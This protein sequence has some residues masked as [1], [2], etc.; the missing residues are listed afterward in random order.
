MTQALIHCLFFV[1]TLLA[2]SG[3]SPIRPAPVDSLPADP[4]AAEP[5]QETL[6][7]GHPLPEDLFPPGPPGQDPEM[8]ARYHYLTFLMLHRQNQ[9]DAAVTALEKAIEIDPDDSFLKRDLIRM[10][11]SMGQD[12]TA[13]SLLDSLV[14]QHPDN[15]EN[16]L[17]MARLKKDDM[18]DE[19]MHPLLE[20]ILELDPENRE[21]YLRLG[22]IYM[23]N[24]QIPEALELFSRM[25]KRLPD[26]YVAHF[27][28]GEAHFLS[29]NYEAAEQAFLRTIDLEPD[30]IEPRFRLVDILQNPENPAG[31]TSPDRLLA[32]YEQILAIDPEN[33]R[34]RLETALLYHKTGQT[35]PAG[36]RLS[37]LGK[38]ALNDTR[39]LMT[40]VDLYLSQKRYED[41]VI[42]FSQ[43]L[44]ADPD[45]DNFN[46]FLG[47][48]HE[49]SQNPEQAIDHYLK[50]SPAHPQYKKTL[51]TIAF[52][53]REAGQTDKAVAFLERHHRQS[54]EDIDIL[55]YLAAFYEKEDQLEKAMALLSKGLEDAPENTSLL[56]RLGAV[57]DKAGL[58]D[59]SIATMKQVIHLDPE[60]ASALNYLGY[61]YADL[62]I[63]LDQAET[64][65][66]KALDI[67]PDDGYIIDSMGWVYFQQG[68]YDK[69]VDY[70]ERAAQL[71]D[72]EAI[73][74]EHLADA[75]LKT[76][77]TVKALETY[78]RSLARAEASD[79]ELISRVTGKIRELEQQLAHPDTDPS[80]EILP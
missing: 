20:R 72:Y 2:V 65:I 32:M 71:T 13:M 8:S 54:P 73:I 53:Y 78:H 57:Q 6:L 27:Y 31:D 76:G 44:E 46:F 12:E 36:R 58:K 45:N 64:L 30:L 69:A 74:A 47:M 15:V 51:L 40:A 39:L 35:D 23:D 66:R 37:D 38:E 75:Y 59:E 5:G 26:Y 1:L 52:L 79:T 70:L 33:S 19:R 50:V 18:R 42:V 77:Q 9:F 7:Q 22:K 3:C 62:G 11:L 67:R 49:S 61:T 17:M 68:N 60:D 10:Y 55:T 41:A 29:G 14:E 16:L 25:A 43:M 4:V 56:F 63:H 28:L 80:G 34:A 24:Q 21:T 48:A